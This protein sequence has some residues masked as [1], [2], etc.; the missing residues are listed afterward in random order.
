MVEAP[1]DFLVAARADVWAHR[2]A[3]DITIGTLLAGTPAD[4]KIIEGYLRSKFRGKSEDD[5]AAFVR[6]LATKV[7]ADIADSLPDDLS[8]NERNDKVFEET[9]R[10]GGEIFKRDPQR[11]GE[12]YEEGRKVAAMLKEAASIQWPNAR[13]ERP[14][15]MHKNAKQ[16]WPEHVYVLEERIPTGRMDA[17]DLLRR[18]V[19]TTNT[20]GQPQSGFAMHE[21]LNDITLGF[22]IASDVDIPSQVWGK[23]LVRA[24]R[25]GFGAARSMG[26]GVFRVTRFEKL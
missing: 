3:C 1:L 19:H 26:F 18:V 11:G 16:W 6:S 25:G 22:T 7:T 13:S 23:V 17:D 14:A 8:E 15:F 20:F 4:P 21:I 5:K 9:A 10:R 12:L 24:E 2:W